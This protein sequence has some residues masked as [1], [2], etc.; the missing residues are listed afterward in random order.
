M[1]AKD[2][3]KFADD[4]ITDFGVDFGEGENNPKTYILIQEEIGGTSPIDP[5]TVSTVKIE[6]NAVFTSVSQSLIDGTLIKQGD[7]G[8]T[9]THDDTV[10]SQ[11]FDVNGSAL[12]DVNGELLFSKQPVK[13]EQNMV[14][15]RDGIEYFIV[16]IDPVS[17]YGT[18]IVK[19]FIARKK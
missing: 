9:S 2:W 1:S 10:Y 7:I 12:F 3:I 16:T 5:P 18:S 13:I 8:V 17:P 4:L 14:I 11:L 19:K 6:I 15:E